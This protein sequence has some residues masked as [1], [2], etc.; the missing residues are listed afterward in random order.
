MPECGIAE[1]EGITRRMPHP[2]LLLSKFIG[3]LVFLS[4]DIL[5]PAWV[6]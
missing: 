1:D 6:D 2:T 5:I 3:I 4:R